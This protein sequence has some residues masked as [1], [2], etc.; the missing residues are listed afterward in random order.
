MKLNVVVDTD[1]YV[2]EEADPTDDWSRDSTNSTITSV[3][4]REGS[5]SVAWYRDCE[6]ELDVEPGD[7]VYVVVVRYG[8]GDTFGNDGGQVDVFEV[9]DTPDDAELFKMQVDEWASDDG[10]INGGMSRWE[11]TYNGKKYHI[12]W[13][14]YFEWFQDCTIWPCRVTT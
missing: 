12:P 5:G 14:G 7:T 8:T 10:R 6:F 11:E 13:R 9:F 4:V 2:T 1:T 3:Y